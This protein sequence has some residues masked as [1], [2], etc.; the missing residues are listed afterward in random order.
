MK[1]ANG[2][3]DNQ[4]CP[5]TTGPDCYAALSHVSG[6]SLCSHLCSQLYLLPPLLQRDLIV[7]QL[8]HM[9]TVPLEI[10]V[11]LQCV[12]PIMRLPLVY[13]CVL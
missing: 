1:A 7:M 11:T 5:A 10:L 3:G 12:A 9:L 4:Q 8:Y 6:I 13:P 2:G